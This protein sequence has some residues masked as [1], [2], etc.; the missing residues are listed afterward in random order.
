MKKLLIIV[1]VLLISS[2][3]YAGQGAAGH[4][5]HWGYTGHQGPEHWA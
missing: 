4:V 1:I 5:T 2:F 3:A